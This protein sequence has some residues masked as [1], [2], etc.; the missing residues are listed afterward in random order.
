MGAKENYL[1]DGLPP[2][3]LGFPGW[4][5][6]CKA[7]LS[8]KNRPNPGDAPMGMHNWASRAP[9]NPRPPFI[10]I[11][12]RFG[13]VRCAR[14]R[15]FLSFLPTTRTEGEVGHGGR[16][17]R[18]WGPLQSAQEA[19]RRTG[20]D[21]SRR[22]AGAVRPRRQKDLVHAGK[23]TRLPCGGHQQEELPLALRLRV[24]RVLRQVPGVRQVG[25][26]LALCRDHR[27]ARVAHREQRLHARGKGPGRQRAS[28]Q[29]RVR[30]RGRAA[31][32]HGNDH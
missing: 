22:L 28:R 18:R 7:H 24:P 16:H 5:S 4:F 3:S 10:P 29:R 23:R 26:H 9:G 15:A 27:G 1:V 30:V 25:A 14:G 21:Q 32:P 6:A 11:G 8:S 13:K 19:D 17:G 31:P 12:R 20:D 2:S